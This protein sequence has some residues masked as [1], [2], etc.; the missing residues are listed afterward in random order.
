M[1]QVLEQHHMGQKVGPL[2]VSV[3]AQNP[4]LHKHAE[5]ILVEL[6]APGW[7][8]HTASYHLVEDIYCIDAYLQ[9]LFFFEWASV[10][11]FRRLRATSGR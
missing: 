1:A 11:F 3:C 9:S 7:K 5:Q 8:S 6:A 10:F 4:Q 2:C